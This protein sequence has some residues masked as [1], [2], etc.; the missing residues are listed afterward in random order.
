MAR[1][2]LQGALVL[3]LVGAGWMAA[4]AQVSEPDFELIVDAPQGETR[5]EC[6]RGCSLMWIERGLNPN[7]SPRQTFTF[8][9]KGGSVERCS[10]HRVGGWINR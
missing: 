10:S 3:A 5:I 8:A 1:L 2:M 7:N 6:V 9:C 4:K